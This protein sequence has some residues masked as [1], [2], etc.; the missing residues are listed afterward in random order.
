M[1]MHR[2]RL[3]GMAAV[4]LTG[5]MVVPSFGDAG[6]RGH[7]RHVVAHFTDPGAVGFSRFGAQC[8]VQPPAPQ[9]CEFTFT[10]VTQEQGPGLV[11]STVYDGVGGYSGDN[12]KLFR[13]EV[14]ETF[15]G[16]VPGCGSA[17]GSFTWT[18]SGYGDPR[19]LDP[20]TLSF[21]LWG[22]VTIVPGSGTGGLR[23]ISG[24]LNVDAQVTWVPPMAQKG[25]LAGDVACKSQ[26][27]SDT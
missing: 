22:T 5:A 24:A 11:G 7:G 15:T 1:G 26:E 17:P 14:S 8:P 2:A 10:G 3:S 13:W 20:S 16:T 25:T 12:D 27:P 6:G 21:P 4:V 19:R 9:E 18:G 23:G